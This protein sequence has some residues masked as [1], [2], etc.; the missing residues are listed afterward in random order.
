MGEQTLRAPLISQGT[1]DTSKQMTWDYYAD[2]QV[3]DRYD[4]QHQPV[5]YTYNA[6]NVLLTS[7][8]AAGLTDPSQSYVDTQ[9]TLDDLDRVI[10]TDEKTQ[11]ATTW[12]FASYSY[13]A[14]NNLTDQVVNGQESAPNGTQTQQGR[15]LHDDYDQANWLSDHYDCGTQA[16]STSCPNGQRTLE[17]FTANGQESRRELD[18]SN[19]SGAWSLKQLNTWDYYANGKVDHATTTNASGT[20]LQTDAVSYLDA[21]NIYVDGNRTQDVYTLQQPSGSSSPC[22]ST[23]CTA[24]YTY[25]PRD[26]L[27]QQND[28]H[29]NTTSYN[30]DP[31]GNILTQAQNGSTT[32]TYTYNGDQI[33]TQTSGGTTYDYWYDALGRQWCTTTTAGSSADC[34]PSQNSTANAALVSDYEY[35]Y[36]DRLTSYRAFSGGTQTDSATYIYDALDRVVSETE[37]H[38]SLAAPRTTQFSYA[39]LSSQLTQEQLSTNGTTTEAKDYG[40]TPN[41]E[42]LTFTDTPYS[43]GAPQSPTTY[44]YGV[45]VHDS[46]DLLVNPSGGVSASY[47]YQPYGQPDTT[48]TQGDTSTTSPLNPIRFEQKRLDSGSQSY[49][50]GARN[51]SPSANHF[52]TPDVFH[53]ALSDVQLS[54][55]PL[56]QDRYAL[57]GGNPVS[58]IDWSGHMYTTDGS[59]G[60]MPA[61]PAPY[62]DSAGGTSS[63][64][65]NGDSGT[66]GTKTQSP[67]FLR[68]LELVRAALASQRP[69]FGAASDEAAKEQCN[70]PGPVIC[71]GLGRGCMQW[72]S[73]NVSCPDANGQYTLSLDQYEPHANIDW[74]GLAL[75]AALFAVDAL[76]Q[77]IPGVDVASDVATAERVGTA[78]TDESGSLLGRLAESCATNSFTA[79]TLVVMADGTTKAISDVKIGDRVEATDPATGKTVAAIVSHLFLNDDRSLADVVVRQA[80]GASAVL[81][82]TQG[83]RFWD[84]SLGEWVLADQ[85]RAG[86]ALLS[87]GGSSVTVEAVHSWRGSEWMYDLTVDGTHTFYAMAGSA[88]VLVHNCGED[89]ELLQQ[90]QEMY[91][92]K[93]GQIEGH[94]IVPQYLGGPADGPIANIDGAYHQLLTNAFRQQWAYGQGIPSL[95]ELTQILSNVYGDVPLDVGG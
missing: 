92:N 69:G 71:N 72:K 27:V 20:T 9:N 78:A 38:P 50:T 65:A 94:H 29:G 23:S 36:L 1:V 16:F 25:N 66:G 93:A 70:V 19:A 79:G 35:D 5:S 73:G 63:Q 18:Q 83:H 77:E 67:D 52:L 41:G 8:N 85:L 74:G 54:S 91:P 48:L 45:N 58:F 10:R 49:N 64:P 11:T 33:A 62:P 39:G 14:N 42:P 31:N 90:A 17:Q 55:D 3:K 47:G 13:D 82:T 26:R 60:G 56:T 32:A 40:Y 12:T 80:N 22:A 43:N 46:V 53:G 61:D 89:P 57:T 34:G 44:T 59:A 7:H 28:G 37:S 68:Y 84:Q 75:T 24:T 6:D 95:D 21:N 30:L 86:D 87:D 2:G 15:S 4:S 51:Y 81:H 88:P 76:D